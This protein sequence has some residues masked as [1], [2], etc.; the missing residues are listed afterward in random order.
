MLALTKVLFKAGIFP[1][2]P[3]IRLTSNVDRIRFVC[4]CV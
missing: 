2:M 4:V 1:T 3:R